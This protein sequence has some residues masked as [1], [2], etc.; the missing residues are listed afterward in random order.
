MV[1]REPMLPGIAGRLSRL[2][3]RFLRV[4]SIGERIRMSR[5]M[6]VEVPVVLVA[7]VAVAVIVATIAIMQNGSGGALNAGGPGRQRPSN[8]TESTTTT[9]IFVN[10]T[11]N[12]ADTI[13]VTGLSLCPSNCVYP[14][15]H[16]SALVAIN[17]SVPISTLQV[18]VNNSYDGMPIQNPSV[19]TIACTTSSS[20]TCSV[21]LG[22]SSYS[23]STYA[24][25]TRYYATC[26]LLANETSCTA[27]STGTVNTMTQYAYMY[28]GSLPERDIP[29]IDEDRGVV[30]IF[31]FIATFQDGSVTS[32]AISV[33]V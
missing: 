28:K 1:R 20:K 3:Q 30:Y 7:L 27:T 18:Y 11:T 22:G 15:P 6:A 8:Y 25:S 32:E 4:F 19:T 31:T 2:G 24:S 5:R 21:E 33:V 16:V 23:N 9:P 13:S 26:S 12:P 17:G 10:S 14:A 29:I